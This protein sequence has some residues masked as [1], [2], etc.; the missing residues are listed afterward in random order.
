MP[1]FDY[2]SVVSGNC[3]DSVLSDLGK[4]QKRAARIV[5]DVKFDNE[6][7]TPSH[8]LFTQ[9]NWMPLQDRIRYHR[10]IQTYKYINGTNE[11]GSAQLFEYNSN[12]HQYNTRTACKNSLHVTRQHHRSFS[13]LGASLWNSIPPSIRNATSIDS[14][15]RRYLSQYNRRN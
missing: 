8:A 1:H 6:N 2:C 11:Q 13:Y 9:L 4:L 5:L 12:V 10:A 14:F 7:T 3:S 15:R